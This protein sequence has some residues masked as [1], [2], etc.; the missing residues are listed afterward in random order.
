MA[1]VQDE[2]SR[3]DGTVPT[4]SE[5]FTPASVEE[6]LSVVVKQLAAAG[7]P[8]ADVASVAAQLATA[9][10]PA[11]MSVDARL[12]LNSIETEMR[13]EDV[14]LL[15]SGLKILEGF[16]DGAG[17]PADLVPLAEPGQREHHGGKLEG[18]NATSR[19]IRRD[20]GGSEIDLQQVEPAVALDPSKPDVLIV[21]G[22]AAG[23]AAAACL[24]HAGVENVLVLEK[25]A[26]P[27]DNWKRRY[28]RLHLHDIID[29]CHLPYMQ[30][31]DNF[32][33]FPTRVQFGNY[34]QA[35]Q[36]ALG[37]P[38]RTLATVQKAALGADGRWDVD[39]LDESTSPQTV[40]LR[41]RVLIAANGLFPQ[42][43]P[44]RP[45]IPGMDS[46][47]GEV[48]HTV[49]YHSG[50]RFDGK[51]VLLV[52]FGNSANDVIC[53][54]WEN[55]AETTTLIRSPVSLVPRSLW[56]FVETLS[57]RAHWLRKL[58]ATRVHGAR[59]GV[60]PWRECFSVDPVAATPEVE[61]L[62]KVVD[63]VSKFIS[64]KEFAG[65]EDKGVNLSEVGPIE[66]LAHL[67]E[68]PCIDVGAARL[69]IR[70]EVKVV[71]SALA[72]FTTDG[73]VFAD[74][75]AEK[76]DAV[77]FA[78]GFQMAS[79]HYDWLDRELCD[80]IGRGKDSIGA[81]KQPFAA[82]VPSVPGLFTF[83]GRLQML[84]EGGPLLAADVA[85]FLQGPK[86]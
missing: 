56:H 85:K 40:R 63:T 6:L 82:E 21:G 16:A 71:T 33:T 44:N 47:N 26:R 80:R 3:R 53:D 4:L 37:I 60:E 13:S 25:G 61:A 28:D 2:H 51:K 31:P 78:T 35:Y 45:D 9:S 36:V 79:G 72:R 76:Y 52:G 32:P 18:T 86:L 17:L 24:L 77:V 23:L 64:K 42:T 34:L 81:G 69:I 11:G 1:D 39:V 29:E 22:A 30:M 50:A 57:Y 75:R 65:I 19:L 12:N 20:L 58:L 74:G 59:E 15:I 54:L 27:G 55:G 66:C 10:A 68:A 46:F 48:F 73:V 14:D 62:M 84:R 8:E 7:L 43:Q 5:P 70:D 49:D 67:G 41:P 83:Y 38:M